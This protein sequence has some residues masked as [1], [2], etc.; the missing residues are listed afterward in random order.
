MIRFS[1]PDRESELE[2]PVR[3]ARRS[4]DA[5][6]NGQNTLA[7]EFRRGADREMRL[8]ENYIRALKERDR[9]DN[10]RRIPRIDCSIPVDCGP[11]FTEATIQNIS[12]EGLL[13][14]AKGTAV[15]DTNVTV[16][17]SLPGDNRPIRS[18]C[19]VAYV[20]SEGHDETVRFGAPFEEIPTVYRARIRQ[21]I[22]RNAA[23]HSLRST[24]SRLDHNS[25]DG[26]SADEEELYGILRD[27]PGILFHILSERN[28]TIY[29]G[30]RMVADDQSDQ[31]ISILVSSPVSSGITS[32][33]TVFVSFTARGSN[34]YFSSHVKTLK[35]ADKTNGAILTIENPRGIHRSD[36]RSNRR[37][38]VER[39]D[40]IFLRVP[41]DPD[42]VVAGK[43][44]DISR[45]G[46]LCEIT[47]TEDE[48]KVF[49]ADISIGY[50]TDGRDKLFQ[51]GRIRH[52]AGRP[53]QHSSSEMAD[54]QTIHLGVETGVRL[55]SLRRRV[56]TTARWEERIRQ[57][58]ESA[59]EDTPV[60]DAR[61]ITYRNSHG[62]EIVALENRVGMDGPDGDTPTVVI[63]PP[64]FGKK[65]EH[66]APLALGICETFRKAGASV[67]VIRYDGINRPGESHNDGEVSRRGYEMLNYRPTQGMDD[68]AATL[69]YIF[70]TAD[71]DPAT[72]ILVTSSMSSVDARKLLVTEKRIHGWISLMGVPAARTTLMNVLAGTDII[73]NY[74]LNIPN[75]IRGML[76]HLVDMDSL[77]ADLVEERYAFLTDARYDMARIAIPVL[78]ISGEHDHW[79]DSAEV[80]D[81]MAVEAGAPREIIRIPTGHNLRNSDDAMEAFRIISGYCTNLAGLDGV[82]VVPSR[83][84]V[85]KALAR[86]RER[87]Y[88]PIDSETVT[89][90]WHTYLLG[91]AD[92]HEGYDFYE[93]L[94]EFRDFISRE[95]ELLSPR[96]GQTIADMGCGTGLL[97]AAILN[98]IVEDGK[99]GP[100]AFDEA[101][102]IVATDLI[103]DALM[104]ARDK[105][106]IIL[107]GLDYD[108]PDVLRRGAL[109]VHFI[110]ANLEPDRS[111]PLRDFIA[112]RQVPITFLKGRIEG[113]ADSVVDR[114]HEEHSAILAAFLRGDNVPPDQPI[115]ASEQAEEIHHM[116]RQIIAARPGKHEDGTPPGGYDA[117]A[118]SLFISYI[119]NPDYL[120]YQFHRMLK[121][122]GTILVSSMRPDSDISKIFTD[123]I[124]AIEAG[125]AD[126][127]HRGAAK[128][129]LN[130]AAA[131]FELEEEGYFR[132]FTAEELYALLIN[133]GFRDVRVE[134]SLGNPPQAYIATGIAAEEPPEPW[135]NYV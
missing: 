72:V 36:N 21:F 131:L 18:A 135:R 80:E 121:P 118:A 64:A 31:E 60:H 29:D 115:P 114:W 75:G 76:G 11:G 69:D 89:A 1:L 24:W 82:G 128:A 42:T 59:R 99:T 19:R 28:L 17:F 8:I 127:T 112:N 123:Y 25:H 105:C 108:G 63:I 79:V 77:A 120:L 122:D 34:Y 96:P 94:V 27:T 70:G 61:R 32:G 49:Q 3:V 30:F 73:G 132:F 98:R 100:P 92:K 41:D 86:E 53:T 44:L 57:I 56:I 130:E 104:R 62:Q 23:A 45:R 26:Y 47:G 37:S 10:N 106:R 126:G 33:D 54:R 43:L 67:V 97:T 87:V 68:I 113:L 91:T 9:D 74:R 119:R 52:V 4:D 2:I 107:D 95:T 88:R 50:R 78:W 103:P 134:R 83:D 85:L 6:G 133:A 55:G 101:T 13:V 84:A 16:V 5:D 71:F 51:Q 93:N 38:P 125:T 12:P 90:Y 7:F 58:Q 35:D 40:G 66:P 129:M 46:F 110:A 48:V 116:S 20:I 65:K 117:L 111:L 15:A 22:E 109:S 14:S 124:G 81:I 102:K 39:N